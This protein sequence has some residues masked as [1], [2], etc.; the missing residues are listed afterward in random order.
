[1]RS[2]DEQEPGAAV[3]DDLHAAYHAKY[4]RYG[5]AIVGGVVS[6]DAARSTHRLVPR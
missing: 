6:P 1:V 4:D 5:A 3:D 2:G